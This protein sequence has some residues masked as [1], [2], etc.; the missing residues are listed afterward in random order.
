MFEA[1]STIK[2]PDIGRY[3]PIFL[4]AIEAHGLP[5]RQQGVSAAQAGAE[6]EVS[7]TCTGTSLSVVIRC[8][9]QAKLNALRYT[10]T[11]LIDFNAREV[12]PLINWQ[13]DEVGETLP[14][15]LRVLIVAGTEEITPRMRRIW[16]DGDVERYDTLDHLHSRLLFKRGRGIPEVWP[17]MTDAGRIRWPQGEAELDTRIY[18]V[19]KV[20]QAN[21]RLAVDF[22]LGDH[23]G[24][25][26]DWAR[27]AEPG[28]G[29]GFVGPAAHG[30]VAAEFNVFAADE[31]GLPGVLRCLE[32][33]D[34]AARGVALLE[35]DGP[36]EEQAVAAPPGVALRWLHRNGAAPG[37][38][39]LL[40]SAF[41][42]IDWPKDPCRASFWC[43]AERSAFLTM[44]REVRARGLPRKQIVA[45]AHWRR[46][47][48]EPEIAATGSASIRE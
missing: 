48:S 40:A 29:V 21:G 23:A 2:F 20:D 9:D 42:E 14:P 10:I 6:R 30:L 37:T 15:D 13:G 45:F 36:Q 34:P 12:S 16:F 17:Q 28:D 19:R 39:D 22:F 47:M 26:T 31:T 33:L 8:D 35:V 18:T 5:V 41:A 32:A 44:W 43:G 1:R 25:A 38:Q 46:G 4:E 27:S 3:F 11:S 24:P 7:L